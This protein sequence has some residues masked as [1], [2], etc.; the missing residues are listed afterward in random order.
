MQRH[1]IS[2]AKFTFV[3][4]CKNK[5]QLLISLAV[6]FFFFFFNGTSVHGFTK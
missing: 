2:W 1:A 3:A 6:P 4:I 5:A